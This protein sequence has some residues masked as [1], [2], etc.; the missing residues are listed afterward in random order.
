MLVLGIVDSLAANVAQGWSRG[1]V[2]AVVA[3]WPAVSLVGSYEMLVWIIRTAAADRLAREPSKDH[4]VA[5]A[6][7]GSGPG[8]DG[9]DRA[10]QEGD[11]FRPTLGWRVTAAI[12]PKPPRSLPIASA[13]R[14]A[15]LSLALLVRCEIWLRCSRGGPFLGAE[16]GRPASLAKAV[17]P[18]APPAGVGGLRNLALRTAVRN[19]LETASP[20]TK[21]NWTLD[22]VRT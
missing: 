12:R 1:F 15:N 9:A 11:H 3:A 8:R 2:G 13:S 14:A 16:D 4:A 17:R 18:P 7:Q 10:Y 19:C 5:R 21:C 22:L 20:I 6:D